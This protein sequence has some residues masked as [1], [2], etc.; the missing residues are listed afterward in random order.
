MLLDTCTADR[1]LLE[2][3][4]VPMQGQRFQP[5]GFADLGAAVYTLPDGTRM[6]LVESAQSMANRL[7]Q[8]I[9]T[10]EGTL[11]PELEGLSCVTALLH[12]KGQGRYLHQYLAGGASSG[13]ALHHC[14]QDVPAAILH[15]RGV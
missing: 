4:L 1:V 6:L 11:I 7:E 12:G 14:R 5:T 10:P 8:T 3:D 2:A 15:R 13:L 9:L